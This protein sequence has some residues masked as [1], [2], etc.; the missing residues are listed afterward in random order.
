[1]ET[2]TVRVLVVDDYEPFRRFVCSTLEKRRDSQGH[3][4][5]LRRIRSGSK[6]RRT[7][8]GLDCARHRASNTEWN[9]SRSTNP[10]ALPRIQ[11]TLC[12]QESSADVVKKLSAWGALGYVV[13]AHAESELLA[14]VE[15]VRQGRQFVSKGLA[16]H[17]LAELDEVQ[18]PNHLRR[19]EVCASQTEAKD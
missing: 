14:A 6:G 11:N 17:V 9:R 8:T 10:H 1:L 15:A 3:R 18:A 4:R 7:A 19:D 16:G 13:K 2:S 5:G 12:S